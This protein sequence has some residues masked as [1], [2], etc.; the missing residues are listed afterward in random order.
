MYLFH[1][2][3]QSDQRP[4]IFLSSD[5]MSGTNYDAVPSPGHNTAP[6]VLYGSQACARQLSRFLDVYV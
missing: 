5:H 3:G 6:E 2:L 1:N 4:G